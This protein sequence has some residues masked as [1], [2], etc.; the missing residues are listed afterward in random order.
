VTFAILQIAKRV[1][2]SDRQTIEINHTFLEPVNRVLWRII[3]GKPIESGPKLALLTYQIRTLFSMVER[4]PLLQIIQVS[5]KYKVCH[6]VWI[7][8]LCSLFS[9]KTKTEMTKQS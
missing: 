4:G 3:S 7:A 5:T 9:K 8:V 2:L 6:V 1:F